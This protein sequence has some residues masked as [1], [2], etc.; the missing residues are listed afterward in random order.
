MKLLFDQNLSFRLAARL[1][2]IF[3]GSSH[4]RLLGL[5]KADDR[6]VYNYA[7]IHDF[8]VISKDGDFYQLGLHY[9]PPPKVIWLNVGNCTTALVAEQLSGYAPEINA[10][11]SQPDTAILV[12]GDKPPVRP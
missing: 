12:I 6:E 9:G 5:E 11:R 7:A 4:V 10:F 2:N 1:A 8:T 3:P